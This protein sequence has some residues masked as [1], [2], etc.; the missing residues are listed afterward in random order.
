MNAW[1]SGETGRNAPPTIVEMAKGTPC[2]H[3][4]VEESDFNERWQGVL[5]RPL[6]PGES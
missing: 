3:N 4:G 2:V 6:P 1:K 5:K